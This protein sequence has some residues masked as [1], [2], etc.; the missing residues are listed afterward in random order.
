MYFIL[1][2]Y[3]SFSICGRQVMASET[4]VTFNRT[5]S[6]DGQSIISH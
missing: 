2:L 1:S 5:I 4:N 6:N 3:P